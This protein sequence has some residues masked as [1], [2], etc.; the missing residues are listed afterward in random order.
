MIPETVLLI[1]NFIVISSL[2]WVDR[3]AALTIPFFASAFDIFL[4][5]QFFAQVPNALLETA[6]MDGG[7]HLRTLWSV[8]VPL[9]KGPLSTVA[10]LE[11]LNSW[12]AL[13][14][15][16]VVTQTARWRPISVGLTRFIAESGPETQLR[17]AG[18][19]IAL[20]PVLF[21]YIL[22]QRQITEAISRTG[23]K[24]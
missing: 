1:P 20:V 22:A 16:L 23:I 8:V 6:R 2:G 21:V 12:N 10:F 11:F 3:L 13:Q 24:G 5:R 18:A 7:S 15:P 4:L 9:S 17:L 19:T 14:W